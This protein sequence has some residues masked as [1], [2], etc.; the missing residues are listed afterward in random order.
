LFQRQTNY[1]NNKGTEIVL[2]KILGGGHSW[3]GGEKIRMFGDTP[4]NNVSATDL[5]WEFF[6]NNPKR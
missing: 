1:K 3:P 6:K 4:V 5:I 2:Y